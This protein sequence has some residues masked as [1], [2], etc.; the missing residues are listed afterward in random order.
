MSITLLAMPPPQLVVETLYLELMAL[1]AWRTRVSR[2][3][4]QRNQWL[5]VSF[6]VETFETVKIQT[7]ASYPKD[8]S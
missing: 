1:Y 3:C 8:Y 2:L 4:I 5:V 6:Y 7:I